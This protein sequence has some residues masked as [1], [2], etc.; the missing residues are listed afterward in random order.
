MQNRVKVNIGNN[1]YTCQVAKTEEEKKQGLQGVEHLAPDEGMLFIWDEEDTREM[2][3]KGCS[4]P[5]D[6]IAIND[7]DEVVMVYQ[8]KPN[9]ET[10]ISFPH[11][12]Y[13]LEVNINSGIIEGD[14]FDIDDSE[15]LDKY[16]MKILAPDGTTQM[17][18]QGSER[19][20]SRK[21]TKSLLKQILKANEI[22]DNTDLF[23]KKC[24]HIGKMMFKEIN[25]QDNREPQYVEHK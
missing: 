2:W 25:A 21:F 24:K 10:L 19:I 14:D 15:D 23:E 3:M 4:I 1:T 12:K 16:V 22:K 11:C 6:Q 20:F 17:N 5:L 18:L 7:D 9:D 8:A 13:L